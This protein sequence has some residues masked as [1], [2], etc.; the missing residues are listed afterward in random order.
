MLRRQPLALHGPILMRGPDRS[1]LW[2]QTARRWTLIPGCRGAVLYRQNH[3]RFAWEAAHTHSYTN[4][5]GAQRHRGMNPFKC[6]GSNTHR[7]HTHTHTHTHTLSCKWGAA[8]GFQWERR[9][10]RLYPLSVEDLIIQNGPGPVTGLYGTP[11]HTRIRYSAAE[12]PADGCSRAGPRWD[13]L[14]VFAH[15]LSPFPSISLF[16]SPCQTHIPTVVHKSFLL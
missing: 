12:S 15:S 14:W 10:A 9:R 6:M 8:N 2:A 5:A 11:L 16:L 1:A 3:T 7:A 13:S 4:K